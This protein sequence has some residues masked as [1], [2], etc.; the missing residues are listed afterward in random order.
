MEL[1]AQAWAGRR[2]AI[3]GHTGFKGS[4]LSLLMTEMNAEVFGF[5]RS[6]LG[7]YPLAD[8]IRPAGETSTDGDVCDPTA[9]GAFMATA[10]PDVVFHL[11]AQALVSDGYSDPVGTWQSNAAGTAVVLDQANA[12]D[13]QAVVV[14]TS[15]K[16]Y[17]NLGGGQRFLE[18]DP[19][20][21]ADPYSASKAGAELVSSSF[22]VTAPTAVATARAGNV[23][24]G[25]DWAKGRLVPDCIKA[26]MEDSPVVLRRPDATRPWQHVL[27]PVVG[28]ALLAEHIMSSEG[29]QGAWNFGPDEASDETVLRVATLAAEG[30]GGSASVEV[31]EASA[32][33]EEATLLAVDSSKAKET[34]G[35]R[36]R[37]T[38]PEAVATTVDWYR[39]WHGNEA[40]EDVSRSQLR[41]FLGHG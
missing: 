37:W 13:V 10:K 31:D 35:Y 30:W 3:T 24:G 11:A 23:I 15:D 39:R 7:T 20:G 28:Y 9:V 18:T 12:H 14:V 40:M 36:P 8:L 29:F 1:N 16:C 2:V 38:M 5:S 27:E 26:F 41:D 21:G 33:F 6:G 22:P 19:L 17:E 4:W 25:A 34:L 32:T